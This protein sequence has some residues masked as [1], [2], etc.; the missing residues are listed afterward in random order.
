MISEHFAKKII[1]AVW[2]LDKLEYGRIW[3]KP[4][5]LGYEDW[6][7]W[8]DRQDWGK[9]G[10]YPDLVQC[11]AALDALR[12]NYQ[13]DYAALKMKFDKGQRPKFGHLAKALRRFRHEWDRHDPAEMGEMVL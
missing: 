5:S 12:E 10:E 4:H 9:R 1:T 2:E 8:Y 7:G 13:D 11:R 6:A 3:H